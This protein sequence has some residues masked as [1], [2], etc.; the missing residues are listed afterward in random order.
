MIVTYYSH[1]DGR[2]YTSAKKFILKYNLGRPVAGN[3]F[4][5]DYDKRVD[6]TYA[7]YG[8]LQQYIQDA[9]DRAAEERENRRKPFLQVE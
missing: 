1:D 6:E 4:L 5:A 2:L 9:I 3:F 7:G 8:P